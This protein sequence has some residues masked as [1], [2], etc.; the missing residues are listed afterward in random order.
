[1]KG[2]LVAMAL[3]LAVAVGWRFTRKA[4]LEARAAA[5]PAPAAVRVVSPKLAPAQLTVSLPG[6]VRPKYQVTLYARSNGFVRG[7]QVDLGDVVKR[8]QVLA[9]VDAPDLAASLAQ[10]RARHEQAKASVT[11]VRAQHER[12]K[13]LAG[14]GNLSAQ[15]LDASAL[16]LTTAESELATTQAELERLTALVGYLTVRAPFDG[17]ITRRHVD[18]GALVASER[19]A[20]FEL[21][22]TTELQVDVEVPQWAA[23]QVQPGTPATLTLGGH[24]V[25]AKV[26]RTAG[27]LDPAL[28]TLRVELVPEGEAKGLVPGAYARV[29]LE[30]PRADPPLLLPGAALTL[31]QGATMVALVQADGRAHFSPVK[32]LRELGKEVEVLGELSPESRLALY[33][34]STLQEG[35]ALTVLAEPPAAPKEKKP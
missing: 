19:T 7:V 32:V 28:R 12:T 6:S 5:A 20:L 24:T 15:D 14:N 27:A 17:T 35:D 10:A 22:S 4:E 9:K 30:A 13:T 21:A 16:R 33:P 25:K 26:S 34:P 18:D 11:L 8:D 23:G 2:F 3:V 31:R 29:T 1:M